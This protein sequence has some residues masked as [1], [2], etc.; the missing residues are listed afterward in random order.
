MLRVKVSFW[1]ADTHC[2]RLNSSLLSLMT[3]PYF[4]HLPLLINVLCQNRNTIHVWHKSPSCKV[5]AAIAQLQTTTGQSLKDL[6]RLSDIK[7]NTSLLKND[8][9]KKSNFWN[10][11]LY[12]KH[13]TFWTFFWEG[14]NKERY[15]SYSFMEWRQS[16]I[17]DI[18]CNYKHLTWEKGNLL[19]EDW[20]HING[21]HILIAMKPWKTE[22]KKGQEANT[23]TA[24]YTNLNVF[25]Y[26]ISHQCGH[27]TCACHY[28]F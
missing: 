10:I 27:L 16:Y 3:P 14:T 17:R 23:E 5:S 8:N 13:E 12:L 18:Y 19:F 22:R 11:F 25:L 26:S 15:K 24:T 21:L 20:K 28:L 1:Q 6:R 7:A 4:M 2:M 9:P